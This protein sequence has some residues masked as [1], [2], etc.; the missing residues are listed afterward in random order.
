MGQRFTVSKLTAEQ[1]EF[2][3]ERLVAGHTLRG[4]SAEFEAEFGTKLPKSSLASWSNAVGDF[5]VQQFQFS[6]AVAKQIV[7]QA[8]DEERDAFKLVFGDFEDKLLAASSEMMARDPK[9]V[10]QAI[11][12]K[13][14]LE[15]RERE[16]DLK[17]REVEL[18]EKQ[19]HQRPVAELIQ[20]F[21]GVMVAT[22]G[23]D[24]EG[25]RWFGRASDRLAAALNA[26]FIDT[27][28]GGN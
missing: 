5:A 23:D 27:P 16:I 7:E 1:Q 13:K 2:I 21:L 10:L 26:R 20:D 19:A 12:E 17:R 3:V 28:T 8:G 9:A 15:Q 18:K 22:I 4:I 11:L 14:R 24:P 6:R 25:L